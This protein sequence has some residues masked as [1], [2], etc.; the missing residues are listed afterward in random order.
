MTISSASTYLRADE[1]KL[2]NDIAAAVPSGVGTEIRWE[3]EGSAMR[4]GVH[5]ERKQPASQRIRRRNRPFF[6]QSQASISRRAATREP[7]GGEQTRTGWHAACVRPG[8]TA[9]PQCRDCYQ[10]VGDI[11][12]TSRGKRAFPPQIVRMSRDA[13]ATGP[14]A[15]RSARSMRPRSPKRP[16][17]GSGRKGS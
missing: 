1:G 13:R 5:A 14:P 9:S 16:H 17:R 3:T 2:R 4:R 7:A 15:S 12:D 6:V 8:I 11:E 10:G